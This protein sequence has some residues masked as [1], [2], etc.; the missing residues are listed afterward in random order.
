MAKHYEQDK[1]VCIA[2]HP[3][4]LT[5]NLGRHIN[6]VVRTLIVSVSPILF[7]SNQFAQHAISH[8]PPEGALTQL[9]AGTASE[10]VSLNGSVRFTYVA[11]PI[12]AWHWQYLIPW[13]RIGKPHD[14][15]KD[16]ELGAKLWA[17]L[18][19]QCQVDDVDATKWPSILMFVFMCIAS[20]LLLTSDWLSHAPYQCCVSC[21]YCAY[22]YDRSRL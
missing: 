11:N 6:P 19:N 21:C 9:W 17:W 1:L 8:S 5:T 16:P 14:G 2:L 15:T 18:E 12:L 3:G 22:H 4:S 10:A 7:I 20:C 13:A